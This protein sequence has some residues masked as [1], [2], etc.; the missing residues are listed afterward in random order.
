MG[1]RIRKSRKKKQLQKYHRLT[2]K[3]E[4]L[5]E[6]NFKGENIKVIFLVLEKYYSDYLNF[7]K[8]ANLNVN[9]SYVSS[10]EVNQC[11]LILPRSLE[12]LNLVN[13]LQIPTKYF[14]RID[15]DNLSLLK[16]EK[17]IKN[18]ID[19]N[20]FDVEKIIPKLISEE[21]F[22]IFSPSLRSKIKKLILKHIRT[23][24]M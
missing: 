12:E 24:L 13:A 2:S 23:L 6:A 7:V 15:V 14:C 11:K 22:S 3:K 18:F 19:N 9:L 17:Y 8:Q 10:D 21:I 1:K 5:G 20:I 4:F 16:I